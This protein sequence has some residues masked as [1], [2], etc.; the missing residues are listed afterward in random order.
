MINLNPI[1]QKVRQGEDISKEE[2]KINPPTVLTR[3]QLYWII[4]ALFDLLGLL[5][6]V[7]L[8]A[9]LLLRKPW[10]GECQ[11]LGWDDALPEWL[12]K[13]MTAFFIELYELEE[14]EFSR[15]LW[16]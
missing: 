3:R 1:K 2:L 8:K 4:K 11:K 13:E 5:A 10:E 16:P 6:P 15:S 14:V 9:N 7:L 12:V